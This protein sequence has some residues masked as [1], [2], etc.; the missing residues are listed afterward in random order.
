[1]ARIK[2]KVS[3][4]KMRAAC[5]AI[6]KIVNRIEAQH[7]VKEAV[8]CSLTSIYAHAEAYAERMGDMAA[9]KLLHDVEREIVDHI[10]ERSRESTKH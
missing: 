7:G 6:T 8:M 9:V 3:G 10:V 5:D 2:V 4:A 1:M